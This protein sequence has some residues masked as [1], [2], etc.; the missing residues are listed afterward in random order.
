LAK[1]N[2]Q[3]LFLSHK[4]RFSSNEIAEDQQLQW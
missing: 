1:N 3:T 2:F 4:G